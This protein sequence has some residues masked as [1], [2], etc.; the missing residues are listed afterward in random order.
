MGGNGAGA[1]SG[2]FDLVLVLGASVHVFEDPSVSAT[3]ELETSGTVY[4]NGTVEQGSTFYNLDVEHISVL[5][6]DLANDAMLFNGASY[7][8]GGASTGDLLIADFAAFEEQ[9]RHHRRALPLR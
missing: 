1:D 6:S 5:G 2:L 4:I 8:M 7:Y 3:R 9:A